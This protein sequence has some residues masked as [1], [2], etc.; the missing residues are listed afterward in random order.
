MSC[1]ITIDK[2]HVFS[3]GDSPRTRADDLNRN[4]ND[5]WRYFEQFRKCVATLRG[6]ADSVASI[7]STHSHP[8]FGSVAAHDHYLEAIKTRPKTASSYTVTAGGTPVGVL[9]NTYVWSDGS[10]LQIP[11]VT[12]V[13]GYDVRFTFSGVIDFSRI[14]ISAWYDG[15][16]THS[17][18]IQMYD[19]TNAA[20]RTLWTFSTG[21]GY[22]YRF[23]DLPVSLSTRRSD[24]I[25][26]TREV[27]LRFYHKQTGAVAHK[28]YIDYASIM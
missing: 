1:N 12:G 21:L 28:L 13:P 3:P 11:E 18:E 22:N 5:V 9:A 20:W 19:D 25:N 24:Y 14:G 2:P 8:E 23:S 26:S 27:K 17:C 16:S 10:V 7:F 4:V 6:D 15:S